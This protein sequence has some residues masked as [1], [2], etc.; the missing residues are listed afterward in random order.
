MSCPNRGRDAIDLVAATVCSAGK[1]VE[2]S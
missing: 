1:I 2:Q